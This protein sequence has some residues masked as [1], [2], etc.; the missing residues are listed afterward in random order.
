MPALAAEIRRW[1]RALTKFNSVAHFKPWIDAVN[2]IAESQK[3]RLKI[4]PTARRRRRRTAAYHSRRGRWSF[5]RLRR[6]GTAAVRV[7]RSPRAAV[8]RFPAKM[9]SEDSS[10]SRLNVRRNGEVSRR[11]GPSTKPD[12]KGRS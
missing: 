8:V 12:D 1:Q 5:R 4:N 11:G 10:P 2:P 6:L 7:S 3:F 9:G